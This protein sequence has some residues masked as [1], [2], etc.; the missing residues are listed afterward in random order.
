MCK[1]K[2]HVCETGPTKIGI[3]EIQ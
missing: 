2:L 3:H 1:R